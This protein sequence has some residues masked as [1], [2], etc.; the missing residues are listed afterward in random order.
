MKRGDILV[1]W[2]LDRLD[3]SLPHLLTII[4]D[5]KG[6]RIAF[7][8]LAEQ[9]D[10]TIPH[11][12]LLFSLFGALAQYERALIRERMMAGLGAA[13][14]RGHHGGRP[15]S[16]NAEDLKKITAALNAGASKASVCRSF[17]VPRSALLDTLARIGCS[18]R[19]N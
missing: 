14:R 2:K 8:S 7:C 12:E 18:N 11:D 17:K 6:R 10:T 16:I 5:L 4:T 15:P 13:K 1:V 19:V 3:R 9:I